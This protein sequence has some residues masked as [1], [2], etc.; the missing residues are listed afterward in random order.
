MAAQAKK[1]LGQ[2]TLKNLLNDNALEIKAYN[3]DIFNLLN[4][5]WKLL[6]GKCK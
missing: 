1:A 3:L 4:L 6:I 2:K 5:C